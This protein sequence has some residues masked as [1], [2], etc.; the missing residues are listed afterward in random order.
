AKHR[1]GRRHQERNASPHAETDD[2]QS[3]GISA[4]ASTEKV[5]RSVYII[6]DSGISTIGGPFVVVGVNFRRVS[7]I[8]IRSHTDV[9]RLSDPPRHLL[10]KVSNTI[11]ILND[12]DR[13]KRTRPVGLN[14]VEVHR[15]IID[16]ACYPRSVHDSPP[17]GYVRLLFVFIYG[18]WPMAVNGLNGFD[19]PSVARCKYTRSAKDLEKFVRRMMM[20]GATNRSEERR[21]GK[22]CRWWCIGEEWKDQ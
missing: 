17:I 18:S 8:K 15:A 9:T 22:E 5:H 11:L 21:V 2:S 1:I 4:D 13:R 20:A 16:G 3:S 10:R 14:H 12:D 19:L 7:M 6:E